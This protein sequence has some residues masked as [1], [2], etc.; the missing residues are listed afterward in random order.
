MKPVTILHRREKIGPD[1]DGRTGQAAV[2]KKKAS[3]VFVA[4]NTSAAA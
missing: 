1:V 2:Q 4:I 3:V